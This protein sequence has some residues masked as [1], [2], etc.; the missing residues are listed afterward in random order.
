MRRDHKAEPLCQTCEENYLL[1]EIR[2]ILVQEWNLPQEVRDQIY[3]RN[4]TWV[5]HEQIRAEIEN[6]PFLI[7]EMK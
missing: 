6:K 1:V 7:R 5:S 2:S 3:C 4:C